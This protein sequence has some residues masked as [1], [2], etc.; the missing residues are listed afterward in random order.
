[1]GK[2]AARFTPFARGRIVGKFEEGAPRKRILHTVRKKDGKK[3]TPRA[4]DKVLAHVRADS[5]WQGEDSQAG[6]RPQ[7]LTAAEV[8]QL[9]RLIH[10]EV[11]LAK[12]TPF[13]YA[14]C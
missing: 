1:M 4:I 11:G 5:S 13:G 6:G 7:A 10:Q 9:K 3:A 14:D 2:S 8:S 12:V